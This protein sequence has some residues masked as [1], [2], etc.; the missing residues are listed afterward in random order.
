MT[1]Q[2]YLCEDC[3]NEINISFVRLQQMLDASYELKIKNNKLIE[4]VIKISKED[5]GYHPLAKEA[6]ELLKEIGEE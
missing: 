4:F 6:E 2:K 1:D 3:D 5:C